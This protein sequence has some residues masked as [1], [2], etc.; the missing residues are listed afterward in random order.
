MICTWFYIIEF[1]MFI[2]LIIP[3]MFWMLSKVYH[4]YTWTDLETEILSQWSEINRDRPSVCL[5]IQF[6]CRK[7]FYQFFYLTIF[8][9]DEKFILLFSFKEQE[10]YFSF[11]FFSFIFSFFLLYAEIN[12][13]GKYTNN[14]SWY[15]ISCHFTRWAN[16]GFQAKNILFF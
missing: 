1:C 6:L 10:N 16:L 11:K 7:V 2:Q 3:F 4:K 12:M 14:K 8:L 5:S 13:L 9:G 15:H